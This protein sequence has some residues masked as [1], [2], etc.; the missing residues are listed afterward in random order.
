VCLPQLLISG[1]ISDHTLAIFILAHFNFEDKERLRK[2]AAQTAGYHGVHQ[3]AVIPALPAAAA[4]AANAAAN[5][6]AP[7]VQVDNIKMC[8]CHAHGLSRFSNHTADATC[9]HPGPTTRL[10]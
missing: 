3:A 10:T 8:H 7:A 9:S 4:A 5:A 6:P 1:V 2:R